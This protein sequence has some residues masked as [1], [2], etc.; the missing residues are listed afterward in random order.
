VKRIEKQ[1]EI[2]SC[3]SNLN[4]FKEEI[5]RKLEKEKPDQVALN[6]ELCKLVEPE[7]QQ[8]S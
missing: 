3:K 5:S 4:K 2:V 6:N 1:E 7:R 8:K